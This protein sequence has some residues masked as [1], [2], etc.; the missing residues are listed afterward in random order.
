MVKKGEQADDISASIEDLS[1]VKSSSKASRNRNLLRKIQATANYVGALS[2]GA[3]GL[4]KMYKNTL[5]M[6]MAPFQEDLSEM[7][8]NAQFFS[9]SFEGFQTNINI[10]QSASTEDSTTIKEAIESFM[11][12]MNSL[13]ST[14][15][16]I[17]G[18]RA[19]GS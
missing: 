11:S 16:M 13:T 17:A 12:F 4:E 5:D 14:I 1:N 9:E 3:Q 15:S 2:H 10:L 6:I 7:E 19:P 18:I 8:A